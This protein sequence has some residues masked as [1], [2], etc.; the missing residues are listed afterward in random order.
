[1]QTK[2]AWMAEVNQ[3]KQALMEK[4]HQNARLRDE[5]NALLTSNQ[6]I[7][8]EVNSLIEYNGQIEAKMRSRDEENANI[9]HSL[10]ESINELEGNLLRKRDECDKLNAKISSLLLDIEQYKETQ[11]RLKSDN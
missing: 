11:L 4:E 2:D 6:Q 8:L 9:V 7:E 3:Y 1:M 10:K 5:V